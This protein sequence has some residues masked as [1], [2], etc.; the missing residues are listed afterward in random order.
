MRLVSDNTTPLASTIIACVE[1]S[2]ERLREAIAIF[3]AI[4]AG[5]LLEEPPP[6]LARL[7]HQCAISLLNICIG[8]FA[9]AAAQLA[10]LDRRFRLDDRGGSAEG[11]GAAHPGD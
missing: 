11:A 10:L 7:R 3:D 2:T 6:R 9:V 5:A 1:D 8:S 4:E